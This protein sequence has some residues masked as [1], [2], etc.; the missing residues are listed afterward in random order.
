[1]TPNPDFRR[2]GSVGRV[3]EARR[4]FLG[5]AAA[6]TARTAAVGAI[7]ATVLPSITSAQNNGQGVGQGRGPDSGGMGPP[8]GGNGNSNGRG[9]AN[10]PGNGNGNGPPCYLRG[11]SV[12]TPSGSVRI[13]DLQIGDLVEAA[14]GE[15]LPVLWMGRHVYRKRGHS[16]PEEVMPIRVAGG[17]FDDQTPHSDLY[18]SPGHALLIDGVFIRVRNLVN[19]RSIAPALPD[20]RDVIEYFNPLLS[21]HQAILA[22]GVPAETFLF[23]GA[24]YE[25]FTNFV[26]FERLYPDR[27]GSMMKPY[28]PIAGEEGGRA[29]LKALLR[30]AAFPLAP[31]RNPIE[32]TYRKLALR[33]EELAS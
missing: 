27:L 33:A 29:H 32:D 10:P 2:N 24:D 11:T 23:R 22:E 13:E 17:A 6:V 9:P 7:A 15:S 28:A 21:T 26:E 8:G 19:G 3:D 5:V 31:V 4:H 16:W 1:M 25:N 30:L 14:D 20:D 12:L 18:L